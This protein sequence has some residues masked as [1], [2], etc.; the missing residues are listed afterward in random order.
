MNNKTNT[1]EKITGIEQNSIYIASGQHDI[2]LNKSKTEQWKK[3][4]KN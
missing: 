4:Q 1:M 2:K 3:K